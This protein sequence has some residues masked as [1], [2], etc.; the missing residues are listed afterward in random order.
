M[1]GIRWI[2]KYSVQS[3]SP[4]VKKSILSFSRRGQIRVC[5]ILRLQIPPIPPIPPIKYDFL[6]GGIPFT[7][8]L[9]IKDGG[10]PFASG[11]Q[12]YDGGSP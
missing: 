1:S 11:P 10:I 4:E 12:I 7:S 6:D 3:Q 5:C 9:A 8:G 2:P